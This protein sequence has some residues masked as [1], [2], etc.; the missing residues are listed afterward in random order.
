M[1]EVGRSGF[2]RVE[3]GLIFVRWVEVG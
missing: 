1:G 2:K 3:I